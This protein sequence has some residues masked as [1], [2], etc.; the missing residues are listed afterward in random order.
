MVCFRL[1]IQCLKEFSIFCFTLLVALTLST[2]ASWYSII[3]LT[4]IFAG[5][6]VPLS[7]W[8]QHLNCEDDQLYGCVNI[9]IVPFVN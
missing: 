5:A 3:G 1:N 6:V 2:I 7:L 4:T 9:G 8:V